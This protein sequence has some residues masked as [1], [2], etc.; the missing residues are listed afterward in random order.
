VR[1]LLTVIDCFTRYAYVRPLKVKKGV[2][3][4]NAFKDVLREAGEKPYM[5]VCDKGTEFT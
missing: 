1:Y 3:V 4:L 5:I 2:E